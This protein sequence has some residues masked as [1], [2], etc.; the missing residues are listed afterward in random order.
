M[1]KC[2]WLLQE[3]NCEGK[4]YYMKEKGLLFK[5]L[6]KKDVD[7]IMHLQEKIFETLE[8]PE[9]LR[10]NTREMFELCVQEPNWTFGAF[11]PDSPDYLIGVAIMFDPGNSDENIASQLIH[12]KLKHAANAKLCMILPKFRGRG[13]EKTALMMMKE[14]ARLRGYDGL[15]VTVSPKNIHST[16]N[17]EATGFQYDHTQKKYGGMEREIWCLAFTAKEA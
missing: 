10:R 4:V 3:E 17:I 12:H 9:L 16:K 15:C 6:T 2:I 7:A 1:R 8:N 11:D 14:R 5:D 13:F